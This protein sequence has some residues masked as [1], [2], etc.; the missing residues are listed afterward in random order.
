MVERALLAEIDPPAWLLAHADGR[1]PF[2]SQGSLDVTHPDDR[3]GLV[4]AFLAS[5]IAPGEPVTVRL[6]RSNGGYW[7]HA[8]TTWLNLVDHEDVGGAC[9]G[10]HAMRER[11]M[12]AKFDVGRSAHGAMQF[13]PQVVDIGIY[14]NP[15]YY[16]QYDNPAF[17]EIETKIATAPEPRSHAAKY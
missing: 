10:D 11:R 12:R 14:A 17:R 1:W 8:E 4:E 9:R 7:H 5:A 16:Y 13:G 2:D 15:N 6:R 3:G